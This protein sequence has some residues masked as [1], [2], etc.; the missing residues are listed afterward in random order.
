MHYLKNK[1]RSIAINTDFEV[2]PDTCGKWVVYGRKGYVGR[3][4][5]EVRPMVEQGRLYEIK[6]MRIGRG[7]HAFLAYADART[8]QEVLNILNALTLNP[9]WVS[10]SYT[11]ARIQVSRR[12]RGLAK[13]LTSCF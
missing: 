10:N 4:F 7:Q 12:L 9:R 6:S 13:V 5:R 3:I 1:D 11:R 2:D 8:K